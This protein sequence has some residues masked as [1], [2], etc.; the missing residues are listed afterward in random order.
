[1]RKRIKDDSGAVMIEGVFGVF[2]CVLVLTFLLAF[3]FYVYQKTVFRIV[4][5]EIAEE[6]A[7][8]Y[9]YKNAQNANNVQKSDVTG[10]GK[11]RYL[12]NAKSFRSAS[13]TKLK[14]LAE[15]RLTL[16]SLAKKNGGVSVSTKFVGD[17]IG[18]FHLEVTVTQKYGFLLGDILKVVRIKNAESLKSTVYAQGT[19]VLFYVNTVKL[20]NY[21]FGKLGDTPL[22]G[23]VNSVIKMMQ[24]VYKIFT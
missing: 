17:D 8:T 15:R 20:A 24:S 2:A 4:A 5:N 22:L 19:D 18:R 23:V 14:N 10:V 21:G 9:K 7:L 12:L 6:V 11:Y 1:M 13:E 16:A 3:G